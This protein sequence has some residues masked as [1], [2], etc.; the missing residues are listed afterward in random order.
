MI[1]I[2]FNFLLRCQASLHRW[3]LHHKNWFHSIPIMH[4]VIVILTDHRIFI[5]WYGDRDTLQR[6]TFFIIIKWWNSIQIS[7]NL[8]QKYLATPFEHVRQGKVRNHDIIFVG[9]V[10][11]QLL[12]KLP[13]NFVDDCLKKLDSFTKI[14]KRCNFLD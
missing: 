13:T 10:A 9:R 14:V 11:S 7:T 8:S 2:Y 6:Y 5:N 1:F 12:S 3:S 4:H